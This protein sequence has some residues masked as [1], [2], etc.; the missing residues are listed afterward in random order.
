MRKKMIFVSL[1]AVFLMMMLP[2]VPAVEYNTAIEVNESRLFEEIQ[3]MNIDELK[4]K[5]LNMNVE[6]AELKEFQKQLNDDTASPQRIRLVLRL[7]RIIL[8]I[9]V[10]IL[11]L[12]LKIMLI[13]LKILVLPLKIIC[14]ILSIPFRIIGR[15]LH[16]IIPGTHHHCNHRECS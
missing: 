13:P 3:N 8:H 11:L 4:E 15:F 5:I 14:G 7:I 6:D 16:I 9:F 10:K 1:L 12:P 2:A